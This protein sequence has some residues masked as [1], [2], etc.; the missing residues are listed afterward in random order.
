VAHQQSSPEQDVELARSALAQNDLEHAIHHIG[1]ALSADPGNHG[2]LGVLNEIITRSPDAMALTEIGNEASFS[3][4]AVRAYVLA[5]RHQ[6]EDALGLICQV[7]E[8]RPDCGYLMWPMWWLQQGAAQQLSFESLVSNVLVPCIKLASGCPAPMD[9]E[10][11]RHKNVQCAAHIVYA[12]R[13][14]NPSD[15]FPY[16]AS[17]LIGRRLGTLDDALANAQHALQLDPSWRNCIGVANVLR[18][19]GRIDEA[20][21]KFREALTYDPEDVSALLDMGDTL[22]GA[23]RLQEAQGVYNEVLAKEAEH[24]WATA[25]LHYVNYKLT[26]DESARS[27]LLRLR[28]AGNNR[29]A[30]LGDEIDPPVPYVTWLPRGADATCNAMRHTFEQM[31]NNPAEYHGSTYELALNYLESPSVFAAFRLQMEMW[32]PQVT[33]KLDVE[34]IQQ[35]DPRQPKTQVDF[36]LWN[37]EGVMPVPNMN[38]PDRRVAHAIFELAEQDFHLESWVPQAKRIASQLQPDDLWHLLGAM[39]HPPRPPDSDW[40]VLIWVQRV[41][42]AAALIIAFIDQGWEGSRRKRALYSLLYG[43]TDWSVDAA[44]IALGVLAREDANIRGEVLQAFAWLQTQIPQQ[45]FTCFEYPLCST[46][47]ACGPHDPMTTQQLEQW[48][49]RILNGKTGSSTVTS[50]RIEPKKFDLEEEKAKAQAAQQEIAAGGGGDPDPVVFPGQPVAKLSDYVR[51]MKAM[52]GGDMMGALSQ[53][54]LD[55]GSYGPVAMQW[56]Q[57]LQADPTLNAKFGQMMGM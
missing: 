7:A 21:A 43:P 51:L 14:V 54:G 29:A 32:G 11:P 48:E 42:V 16:F 39:V 57:A 44:I 1:C 38:P 41:Q 4:A 33:V 53:F 49:E 28:A 17:A 55:M 5:G 45:G 19:M 3:D 10:D 27:E 9:A 25:S 50:S 37:Y 46:W 26:G 36:Q 15:P 18:D 40:R 52:Q 6:W 2:W 13:Q 20:I 34:N 35:P 31:Y 12:I 23:E 22:I 8:T 47:K 30:E 56:G 24:P